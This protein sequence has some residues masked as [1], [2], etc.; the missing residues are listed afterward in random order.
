MLLII[1]QT[2]PAEFVLARLAGHMHA[3]LVLLDVRFA[4]RAR[5][6]VKLY[7]NLIVIISTIDSVIPFCKKIT[8]KRP[9]RLLL[10]LETPVITTDTINISL[11]SSRVVCKVGAVGSRTPL[12]LLTDVYKRFLVVLSILVIGFLV[13]KFFKHTIRYYELARLYR[14]DSCHT[15]WA[16]RY[17]RVKIPLVA[18][19]A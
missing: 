1:T 4:L 14:T 19:I 12:H 8:G 18:L 7:P 17:L 10:A 15:V 3:T 16:C 11:L 9:M 2:Q 5:L 6:S 13:K